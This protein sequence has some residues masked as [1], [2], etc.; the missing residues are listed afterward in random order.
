MKV[1]LTG[2]SGQIGRYLL[3]MLIQR[4]HVCL[5]LSRNEHSEPPAVRWVQGDL[6]L[7]MSRLWQT[8]RIDIWVHM[9]FLPLATPHLANAA[10]VGVKQFIGF[11]ST[12]VFTK[13]ASGNN[14]ESAIIG[15]LLAAEKTVETSC[16]SLG[17]A[18][19]LFRPT[20][21]YGGDVDQ[22]ITF[23]RTMIEHFGFFPLPVGANGLR[24]PVHAEDL[25]VACT[26]AL[27]LGRVFNKSYN[28]SGGEVLSYQQMVE[29]VCTAAGKQPRLLCIRPA[30]LKSALMLLRLLPRYAHLNTDMV[31]RMYDD[32]AFAH[33]D[34][35]ADFQY[36]PRPFQP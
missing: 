14:R 16:T 36:N 18:W 27:A 5:A 12:S 17:M 13:Q 11:S 28:L 19:T 8:E 24:Q 4:G 23:I 33:D 10:A 1:L 7:D 29:R 26:Q 34:A 6:T 35:V 21:I 15:Q 25:A 22:N 9:A 20:M 30:L 2:A 32:M 31:D 3:P